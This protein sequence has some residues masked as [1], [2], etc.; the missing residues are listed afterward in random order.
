MVS[1]RDTRR[2][3]RDE[4]VGSWASTVEPDAVCDSVASVVPVVPVANDPDA[5]TCA[6]AV[7][8]LV[9]AVVP[10]M[11]PFDAS[12][13]AG[14]GA[15][16]AVA[17]T[18]TFL[19]LGAL[20]SWTLVPRILGSYVGSGCLSPSDSGKRSG[21]LWL[22]LRLAR[23]VETGFLR[24][25]LRDDRGCG[26]F[27]EVVPDAASDAAR[28][29]PVGG[30]V[31]E[32]LPGCRRPVAG[33]PDELL[34]KSIGETKVDFEACLEEDIGAA[35]VW[36]G[37]NMGLDRAPVVEVSCPGNGGCT[38]GMPICEVRCR[39]FSRARPPMKP[40]LSDQGER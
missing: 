26:W 20:K 18:T 8:M 14:I 16:P 29:A 23:S 10:V 34:K 11:F 6:V 1:D 24:K 38:E 36:I 9:P 15:S 2:L 40:L 3:D 4:V 33:A 12:V 7:A 21:A 31:E 27:S 35:E 32:C 17:A 39:S 19:G 30:V 22:V 13:G 37:A 5:T 25:P 28:D